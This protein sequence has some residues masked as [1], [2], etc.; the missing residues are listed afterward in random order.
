[1]EPQIARVDAQFQPACGGEWGKLFVQRLAQARGGH[2]R[3]LRTQHA[4]IQARG[5]EQA[6]EQFFGVLE[7]AVDAFHQLTRFGIR[8]RCG[9]Q[10][11]AEQAGGVERLQQ[12][13]AGAGE[14]ARLAEI[15]GFGFELGGAL[16]FDR[17][18][19]FAGAFAHA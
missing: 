19:Q 16:R 12:V 5:V 6:F 11:G 18:S 10:C 9:G 15:G 14:E 7:C 2:R 8:L 3:Q 13:M 1:M 4:G 17:S